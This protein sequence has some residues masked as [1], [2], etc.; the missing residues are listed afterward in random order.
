MLWF[1]QNAKFNGREYFGVYSIL[2]GGVQWG[3]YIGGFGKHESKPTLKYYLMI[4]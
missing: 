3:R 2:V 4:V 1:F